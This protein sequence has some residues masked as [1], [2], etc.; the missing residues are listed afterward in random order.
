MP[1]VPESILTEIK[2]R[3]PLAAVLG[4]RGTALHKQGADLVCCCPLP[5]HND[6]TPSFHVT[7]SENGESIAH[8]FG[9][10]WAGNVFQLLQKLDGCSFVKLDWKDSLESHFSR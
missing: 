6:K 9:C 3:R 10:D 2:S 5:E 4:A 8:C 7:E 1:K